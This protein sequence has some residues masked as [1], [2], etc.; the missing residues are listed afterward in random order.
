MTEG[1]EV[2]ESISLPNNPEAHNFFVISKTSMIICFRGQRTHS[3][4]SVTETASPSM[5]ERR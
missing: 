2:I 3:A 4:S 1:F 5:K